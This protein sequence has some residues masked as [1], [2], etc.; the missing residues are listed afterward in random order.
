MRFF[1]T[2]QVADLMWHHASPPAEALAA[3]S[4][5][6][7]AKLTGLI[8]PVTRAIMCHGACVEEQYAKKTMAVSFSIIH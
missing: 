8:E 7:T 4:V 5:R 2:G 3:R 1:T 6:R